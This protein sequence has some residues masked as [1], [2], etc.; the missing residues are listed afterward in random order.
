MKDA[1]S[2]TAPLVKEVTVP[3]PIEK[4]FRRFT[5][6][7]GSWWPINTHSVFQERAEVCTLEARRGGRFYETRDDGEISVWGTITAVDAP[8][9]VRFTWHPGQEPDG[10]QE[11]EVRFAAEGNGTRV[12]LT[13]SRWE[14]FGKEAAAKRKDY[15]QGWSNVLEHFKGKAKD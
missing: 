13:H 15:D 3:W 10:A 4:A 6:E 5:D 7:I 11:I 8:S 2:D 14:Q 9:M 12:V 1:K